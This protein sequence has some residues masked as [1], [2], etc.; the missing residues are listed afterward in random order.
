MYSKSESR[1][2]TAVLHTIGEFIS[3]ADGAADLFA[4]PSCA[5]Y[6]RIRPH[7]IMATAACEHV[8]EAIE[9][10]IS[11]TVGLKAWRPARVVAGGTHHSSYQ[12]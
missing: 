8:F 9:V 10:D 5:D 4:S 2:H 6:R 1:R 3:G 12:L 11:A 7:F